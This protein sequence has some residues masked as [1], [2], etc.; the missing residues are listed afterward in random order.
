MGNTFR[1]DLG[2]FH[3]HVVEIYFFGSSTCQLCK[4]GIEGPTILYGSVPHFQDQSQDRLQMAAT[5]HAARFWRIAR[6]IAPP[7]RLPPSDSGLLVAADQTSAATTP[8]LGSKET[9]GTVA[10]PTPPSKGSSGPN[11]HAVVAAM[12]VGAAMTPAVSTGSPVAAPALDGAQAFQSGMDGGLQ[13]LV[14]NPGRTADRTVDGAGFVQSLSFGDPA[15]ARPAMVACARSVHAVV[16]AFWLASNYPGGQWRPFW[17]QGSGGADALECLVDG[18][19]HPSGVYCARS[20]RTKWCART[21]ASGIQSR[22][23]GAGLQHEA[24]AT[25]A[26]R[27]LGQLL[28]WRSSARSAGPANAGGMLPQRPTVPVDRP[29]AVALSEELEGTPRSQQW[30]DSMAGETSL[31]WRSLRRHESRIETC[32]A[33]QAHRVF[34]S[35]ATGGVAR[36]GCLWSPAFGLRPQASD[37]KVEKCNLCPCLIVL[38]MSLPRAICFPLPAKRGEG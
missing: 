14:P 6:P 2:L 7:Q 27:S 29:A 28:Q 30:A 5:F 1:L 21:N 33:G 3:G 24:S 17:I 9:S 8:A 19:G 36:I 11:D 31:Y 13:R 20:S 15:L 23:G 16:Q 25:T 34:G 18:V 38:P 37:P 22:P 35:R 26:N 4:I 10:S 12:E 32:R